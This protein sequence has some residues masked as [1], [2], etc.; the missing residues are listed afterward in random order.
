MDSEDGVEDGLE[1]MTWERNGMDTISYQAVKKTAH[2]FHEKFI[3][4]HRAPLKL[5]VNI[6]GW[7]LNEKHN[8]EFFTPF[9]RVYQTDY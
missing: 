3:L 6:S 4:V 1:K 9:L 5:G 7:V 8:P 2:L